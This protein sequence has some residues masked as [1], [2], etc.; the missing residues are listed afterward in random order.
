MTR[1]ES[2]RNIL[3]ASSGTIFLTGCQESNVIDFLRD[4]RLVLNTRHENYLAHIANTFLPLDSKS[5]IVGSPVK[6]ILTM[7][8]DCHSPENINDYAI[9]FDQY[10]MLMK[11]SR[12]KIKTSEIA[13]IIPVVK[14]AL[15]ATEPQEE[16]TFFIDKTKNLAI[17]HLKTSEHY[18]S[19][20]LGYKLVPG[21]FEACMD[22]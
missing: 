17:R 4:D 13:E 8:N 9:G 20:Y 1:R 14:K 18:M 16:L 22:A 19:D 21:N 5:E 3:I 15:E 6:F 11:E 12:L 2:I 10:K 7:L